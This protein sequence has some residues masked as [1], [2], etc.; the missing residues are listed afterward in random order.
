MKNDKNH[1]VKA[2]KKKKKGVKREKFNFFLLFTSKRLVL[3]YFK[4]Q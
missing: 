1:S 4:V 3:F 2:E